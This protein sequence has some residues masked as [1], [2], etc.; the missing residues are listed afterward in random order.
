MIDKASIRAVK[1]AD[2]L[3]DGFSVL[4]PFHESE[5]TAVCIDFYNRLL[6]QAYK[7]SVVEDFLPK[8]YGDAVSAEEID[9]L[10][11]EVQKINKRSVD[12]AVQ[13]LRECPGLYSLVNHNFLSICSR[14][15]NSPESLLKIHWDGILVNT[16]KN[17]QRL[18]KFHT[19][20][21][22]YPYRKNFI[23]FWMPVIRNKTSINGAMKIA[24][25]GHIR[26]YS[27]SE[28]SGFSSKQG[29]DTSEAS[30]FYQLQ[31]P[32]GELECLDVLD[33]DLSIGEALFF[34]GNLPHT[35]TVN[36]SSEPTYAL[37][38]RIYDYRADLT[39]S[40]NTGIKLY[41]GGDGGFP[42]LRPIPR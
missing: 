39:L 16:P 1:N 33:C 40:D 41:S 3:I 24:H 27:M 35:S 12:F 37:I 14:F 6:M 20:Q 22:Y 11:M 8:K 31:I 9:F 34:N 19:E 10:V 25:K 17:E 13:E 30:Y 2:F 18:Y 4:N 36:T 32:P 7:L 26:N 15:L 42:N 23:N 38:G 28:Y 5:I 29:N 21:H